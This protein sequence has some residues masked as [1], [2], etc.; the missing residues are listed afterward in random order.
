MKSLTKGQSRLLAIALLLLVVLVL[1]RVLLVPLWLSWSESSDRLDALNTRLA[2]YQRLQQGMTQDQQTLEQL[3]S[4][5]PTSDWY[6]NE[7]TPAL[8]AA[9]LQ[10]QL[11]RQ[12]AQSGGDVVST[13]ILTADGKDPIP[14]VTVQVRMRAE[15]PE[16][17]DLL[18]SLESGRPVLV[19][20]KLAILSNP[21]L[22][23][24]VVSERMRAQQ[25][26]SLDIRFEMTGFAHQEVAP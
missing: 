24:R 14:T 3:H 1:L 16:L 13:Q 10:Q 21:R 7:A 9:T 19:L 2:V 25:V 22:V 5:Q 6:L 11:H 17:V 26:P 20:D 12:V 23:R 18:Y 15:L 4:S 8:A